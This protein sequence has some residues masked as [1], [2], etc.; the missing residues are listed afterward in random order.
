MGWTSLPSGQDVTVTPPNFYA[1]IAEVSNSHSTAQ[2]QN[3]LK[4]KGFTLINYQDPAQLPGQTPK[5]GYRFVAVIGQATQ[6]ASIPWA[7]P[8]WLPGDSSTLLTA[9]ITPPGVTPISLPITPKPDASSGWVVAM[10]LTLGA[11]IGYLLW[12]KK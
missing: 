4:S 2:I 1:A 7:V 12:R 11:S 10:F 5:S 9:W 6:K 8:W 3:L